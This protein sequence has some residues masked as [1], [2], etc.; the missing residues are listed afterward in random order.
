MYI[1][2]NVLLANSV[3]GAARSS[4]DNNIPDRKLESAGLMVLK[5]TIETVKTFIVLVS[6]QGT[7]AYENLHSPTESYFEGKMIHQIMHCILTRVFIM[8]CT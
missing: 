4:I 1:S 6:Y 8:S 5:F 3:L 7:N 2:R